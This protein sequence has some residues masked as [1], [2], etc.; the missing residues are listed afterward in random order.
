[1][2]GNIS[3]DHCACSDDRA[4]SNAHAIGHDDARAKPDIVFDD[5]AF[6]GDSLFN[7][8][9]IRVF[10]YMVDGQELRVGRRV[11]PVTDLNAPL[12]ADDAVLSDQAVAPH[13]D[14]RARKIAKV[15]DMQHR[16]MH[17]DRSLTNLN[18]TGGSMQIGAL[19]QVDT[20][21]QP[22]VVSEAKSHS[23]FDGNP[24]LGAQDRAVDDPA[25]PNADHGRDPTEQQVDSLL[26]HVSA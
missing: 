14:A 2:G 18:A 25:Y 16:A 5:N 19:V 20:L 26:K 12:P 17:H 22:D 6:G 24:A 11:N 3:G 1:M 23:F 10:I 15:V 8:R 13:P 7:E 9:T 21:A 4:C